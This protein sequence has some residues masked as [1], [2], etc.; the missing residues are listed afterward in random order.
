MK[1]RLLPITLA[2]L[3]IMTFIPFGPSAVATGEYTATLM[4]ELDENIY[5]GLDN[6]WA[7]DS[8]DGAEVSFN[9]HEPA[10]I[11]LL[12][13]EPAKFTGNWTGIST[14]VSVDGDDSAATIG[15]QILS[16][17]VDGHNLGSRP[18]PIIDRDGN[19]E[20]T[21]DIARQW[22]G[23]YDPYGLQNMDPF[24]SLEIT[25]VVGH[26]AT[27]EGQLDT[28]V[29][30]DVPEWGLG[31]IPEARAPIVIGE[32]STIKMEFSNPIKFT[33]NWTG[34]ATSILVANDDDAETTGAHITH[35]IV[36]GQN[37]GPR[38]IPL[39][40]RDDSGFLTI[41]IARQWGGSYDAYNLADMEPFTT[42]EIT[43]IIPNMPEGVEPEPVEHEDLPTHG[44]A[45]L[46]GTFLY[47]GRTDDN[48][49][50]LV[51]WYMFTDQS[52]AF[53]MGVPF[54]V[55]VDL[56]SESATHDVAHWDGFIMCVQTDLDSNPIL[57]EAFIGS[58]KVNGR[59]IN[60][61]ANNVI[62]GDDPIGIRVAL[63][64]AWSEA[65]LGDPSMIGTF[66]TFEITM[67]LG[68]YGVLENPFGDIEPP[69]PPTPPPVIDP[70]VRPDPTPEE[71]NG[72][73]GDGLPGWVIPVIIA[74]VVV[75]ALVIVF[76]V[77]K[78]KKKP[79]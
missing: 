14:D 74:G 3:L 65:P 48:D 55:S 30:S 43:F 59:E 41:D 7:I 40:N 56:G 6:N 66:S 62:V 15:G 68:E 22:G 70:I 19:G 72:N 5:G 11:S 53:E 71:T 29:N 34:I 67:V 26:I 75:I 63:T 39:I 33:G 76:V 44:N 52:V 25:F 28:D 37:L 61:D 9:L 27:L 46:A 4:G 49:P 47:E 31:S 12:F 50:D 51:D 1:K 73:E 32:P 64:T 54:T 79:S 78:S 17:I 42:L 77:L 16:F 35:F 69:A 2:I 10:T 45:W 57:F 58:I 60:F 13:H 24:T 21:L 38:P 23:D 18:I 36:D 20:L 8:M